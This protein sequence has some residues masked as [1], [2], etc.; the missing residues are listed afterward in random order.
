MTIRNFAI[1]YDAI[2]DRNTFSNG[3]TLAGRVIVEVSKQTKITSLTVQAK[4]KANVAWTETHGE[5]SVTYWD[6]EK[7]FSQTQSVL[8]E[9]KADG[10]VTLVAGRHVFP[11]AFQLPN[12]SLPSSFKG[13]HGKIHYRLMAKL[14]RSF[15]AASKAEAKFTFVARA[16]YD[17]STLTTPQHGSKD[18]NVMFFASGNISMDI[19]LPKTGYQQGEGLIVNGEIV[20]SS[21]RKI[22]P[23]YIIYQK[24]SFFAGGQRAVHTTEILKEKGEPLVSSTRE[25]L[26]KVLPLPP[27]ISSTIHNCR[28]L[29]VEYRLKVILDVSFTKNPVIK[30]PFIVLP[31][32]NETPPK[33][34]EEGLY[35]DLAKMKISN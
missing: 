31:L 18:K 3:D 15:R 35:P 10:S 21:T 32:C 20:N 13:V 7:Y 34:I 6:K 23:K 24:Q 11:F 33:A 5:E 30:L 9:D 17:T 8:P 26:Y 29:K 12:Q 27:E 19:F 2:N 16:D 28:I 14:S 22:V 4:G 25:N 1:E